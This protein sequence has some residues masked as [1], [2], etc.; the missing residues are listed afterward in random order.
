[1]NT[2]RWLALGI[3]ALV[4][5]CLA[6]SNVWLSAFRGSDD[7]EPEEP[8]AAATATD[9]ASDQEDSAENETAGLATL[10][11]TPTEDPVVGELME[12]A[13]MEALGVGDDPFVVMDGTFTTIDTLHRGEGSASLYELTD[14]L[15]VLRLEPFSVVAGPDL[16]VVLSTHE[17]PR[18][19]AEAL[20]PTYLDL[21]PLQSTEGSQNYSI[22]EGTNISL[23]HSVVIYSRSLNIIYTT[24]SLTQVRGQ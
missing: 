13:Q 6:S 22:P 11:P 19:S 8:A 2:Q 1:M 7:E 23:Y 20:L 18:T 4:G 24:A 3:L 21:G 12:A 5:L 9:G 16:Q 14:N 15:Y 10:T 17:L